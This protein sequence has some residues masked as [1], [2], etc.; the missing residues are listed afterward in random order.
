[1]H[2]KLTKKG[3]LKKLKVTGGKAGLKGGSD[4][5]VSEAIASELKVIDSFL[6]KIKKEGKKLALMF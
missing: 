6:Q 4:N 1:M 3:T 5:M 2:R